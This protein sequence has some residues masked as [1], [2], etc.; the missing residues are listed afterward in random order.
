MRRTFAA[1]LPFLAC[2]SIMLTA[3]GDAILATEPDLDRPRTTVL[4][5]V[6]VEA[7]GC[8]DE[9]W[10]R[11]AN[12]QCWPPDPDPGSGGSGDNGGDP[13]GDDGWGS[14]G[15]GMDD[16]NDPDPDPCDT[17]DQIIDSES[18]QAG[19]E[20]LWNASNYGPNVPQTERREQYAWIVQTPNGYALMSMGI[21]G[22]PCGFEGEVSVDPPAGAV[23]FVHTHPWAIGEW[24]TTCGNVSS[25]YLGLP[26]SDDVEAS[27][28][29]G[30][31][32]YILDANQIT[33]FDAAEGSNQATAV[34]NQVSRCGY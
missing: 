12:G 16:P 20:E 9:T 34:Q 18:V 31:P 3:C 4:K 28:V 29:L 23:A 24:Q 21:A 17:G 26:S 30:L 13:G 14:G 7:E 10:W 22:A 19:F 6:V 1:Y 32:G 25:P 2:L 5:P 33:R 15:G 8:S 27:R 11:D